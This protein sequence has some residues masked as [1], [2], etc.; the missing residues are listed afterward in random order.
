MN[1]ALGQNP[2]LVAA[3]G[4][5]SVWALDS[6]RPYQSPTYYANL[7]QCNTVTYNILQACAACQGGGIG[8]WS[9]WIKNCYTIY[10]G[11]PESTPN[12]T[13][14]PG[15]ANVD[16]RTNDSWNAL[17]AKEN[18]NMTAQ[19][20]IATT[21]RTIPDASGI[22]PSA[23][24]TPST[25]SNSS[26][27]PSIVGLI[28]GGVIGGIALLSLFCIVTVFCLRRRRTEDGRGEKITQKPPAG[29]DGSSNTRSVG[30]WTYPL[31]NGRHKMKPYDVYEDSFTNDRFWQACSPLSAP[32]E[33]HGVANGKKTINGATLGPHELVKEALELATE[34]EKDSHLSEASRS[35]TKNQWNSMIERLREA[36][37]LENYIA[38]CDLSGSMG[39]LSHSEFIQRILPA[40]SLPSPNHHST[41]RSSLPMIPKITNISSHT[42]TDPI[43]T[44]REIT[45]ASSGMNTEAGSS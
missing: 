3:N 30:M 43:S 6:G 20:V 7:C 36:G 34:C 1:N 22:A 8:T 5:W 12:G 44:V 33:L 18:M 35:I 24:G 29:I 42:Q 41:T 45:K 9:S 26:E 23:F 28:V 10:Y 17:V 14:I 2:C 27:S 40:I 19:P 11:Y 39:T 16:P 31:D 25:P 15:W 21:I 32:E 13:I 4:D 37:T 38:V